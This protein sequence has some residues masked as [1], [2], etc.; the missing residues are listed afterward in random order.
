MFTFELKLMD[1]RKVL[2]L[3]IPRVTVLMLTVLLRL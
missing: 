2:Q 1:E 3:L